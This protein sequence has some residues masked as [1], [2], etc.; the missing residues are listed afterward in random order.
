MAE[1][2]AR[3]TG[4]AKELRR[5]GGRRAHAEVA[6]GRGAARIRQKV[7]PGVQGLGAPAP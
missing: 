6:G 1:S 4:R 3:L 5:V 2:G 7:P